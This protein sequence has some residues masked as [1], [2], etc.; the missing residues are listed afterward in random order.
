MTV[1]GMFAEAAAHLPMTDTSIMTRR[2]ELLERPSSGSSVAKLIAETI[3]VRAVAEQRK[4]AAS[5]ATSVTTPSATL[6]F[7]PTPHKQ[8]GTKL[9]HD[10]EECR[11][12]F[13]ALS[14]DAFSKE[15]IKQKAP[16]LDE[17]PVAAEA[18][19][20]FWAPSVPSAEIKAHAPLLMVAAVQPRQPAR[21]V[22]KGEVATE[23]KRGDK[24]NK[25][26][27]AGAA[28]KAIPRKT[29]STNAAEEGS[30]PPRKARR[31]H[32]ERKES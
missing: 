23:K 18:A 14:A 2:K 16:Q 27:R 10:F 31:Q 9:K 29:S 25:K 24:N 8:D 6:Q 32:K 17:K 26:K 28:E 12:E 13:L 7:T 3:M 1:P 19:N 4:P 21:Q 22:D 30:A 20:D 15:N 5:G 11:Q